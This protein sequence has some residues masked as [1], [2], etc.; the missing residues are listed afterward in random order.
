MSLR[1]IGPVA[2]L[3]F[4]L[5][6]PAALQADEGGAIQVTLKDHRFTPEEIHVKAGQAATISIKNE[7][8]TA[9]EFDSD[10]LKVEKVIAGGQQGLVRLRPLDA[11]RY[12]FMGE[13]HSG[14]AHG[15]VIAE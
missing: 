1:A 8:A 4:L 6:A 5:L 11:G 9:E 7:D 12:P 15:V 13:Y 2:A 3:A 14:T 10:S